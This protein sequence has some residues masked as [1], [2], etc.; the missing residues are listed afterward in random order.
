MQILKDNLMQNE[1]K[2]G[3]VDYFHFL[4]DNDPLLKDGS[5]TYNVSHII[6]TI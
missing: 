4:Q 3:L 5:Y 1:E 2:L 6:C